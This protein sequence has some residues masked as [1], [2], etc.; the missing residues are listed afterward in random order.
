[1]DNLKTIEFY[2]AF[3]DENR[4]SIL[5]YKSLRSNF[6]AMVTGTLGKDYCNM[7]MDVYDA[8]RICCE[9]IVIKCNESVTIKFFNL[10]K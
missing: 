9:D 7:A 5:Q 6:N 4:I 3:Y 10:F 2:K 1:M 8:D